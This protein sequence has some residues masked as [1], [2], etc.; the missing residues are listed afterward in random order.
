MRVLRSVKSLSQV[1]SADQAPAKNRRS[2]RIWNRLT[3]HASHVHSRAEPD[4]DRRTVGRCS[5]PGASCSDSRRD[6]RRDMAVLAPCF[7]RPTAFRAIIAL[8]LTLLCGC[9]C[10]LGGNSTSTPAEERLAL[11]RLYESLGGPNWKTQTNWTSTATS[12]CDGWYKVK[13]DANGFVSEIELVDN[14][15]VGTIPTQVRRQCCGPRGGSLI[16]R[17]R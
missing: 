14:N 11:L 4:V 3:L 7:C 15:L 9:A 10:G 16:H 1:T 6:G 5:A 13:C 2:D 12:P 17:L 8:A